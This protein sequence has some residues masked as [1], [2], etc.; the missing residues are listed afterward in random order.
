MLNIH[1]HRLHAQNPDFRSKAGDFILLHQKPRR[2]II[3]GIPV[4]RSSS[5]T[6][7]QRQCRNGSIPLTGAEIPHKPIPLFNGHT[8]I[9][10][11]AASLRIIIR[12]GIIGR[13]SHGQLTA[14]HQD[15][16][17]ILLQPL[18]KQQ[19]TAQQIRTYGNKIL[20]KS[21]NRPGVHQRVKHT[22][23]IIV[24]EIMQHIG[25]H[26]FL[27]HHRHFPGTHIRKFYPCHSF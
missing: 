10:I 6:T 26:I 9:Q 2:S 25:H 12:I 20:I 3:I 5:I 11:H 22:H 7:G 16:V 13:I 19:N 23:G 27:L 14:P 24:K 8:L 18:R 17:S 1:L 15:L 21:F 4:H